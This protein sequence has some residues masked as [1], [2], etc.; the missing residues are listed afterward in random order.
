MGGRGTFAAGVSVDYTYEVDT[1]FSTDGKWEGVKILKGTKESGEHKL[2][3]SSH[4]SNAYIMLDKNGNF[5]E[6]RFYD[7]N[8]CLY[9]EIAYHKEKSLTGDNHTPVLHYHTYDSSF[10]KTKEGAGGRSK[11]HLLTEEMK[12]KYRKYFKGLII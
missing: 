4:S 12:D 9:L 2:P 11:A 7:D 3:E 8:H 10:S 5:R 6:I 1:A